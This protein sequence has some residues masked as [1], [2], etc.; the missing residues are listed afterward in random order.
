[1]PDFLSACNLGNHPVNKASVSQITARGISVGMYVMCVESCWRGFER[2]MSS[3][4]C[5]HFVD[6]SFKILLVRVT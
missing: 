4:F 1:M 2:D 5:V 6:L 3:V